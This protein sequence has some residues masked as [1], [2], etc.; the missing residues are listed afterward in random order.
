MVAKIPLRISSLMM[1]AWLTPSAS[2]RSLTAIELGSS[3]GPAGRAGAAGASVATA[4]DA[5]A[6]RLRW[7]RG[8]RRGW[9][10]R[11]GMLHLGLQRARHD[12]RAERALHCLRQ[13]FRLPA[14]R[15]VTDIRSPPGGLAARVGRDQ[16]VRAA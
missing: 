10:L 16:S 7:G 2:A 5:G 3:I 9:Y 15:I 12:G 6:V 13:A 14:G 8:P 4:P 1:S 11:G